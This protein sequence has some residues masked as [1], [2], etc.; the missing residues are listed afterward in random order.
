LK[1]PTIKTIN[2]GTLGGKQIR[3]YN[4][5]NKTATVTENNETRPM[6]FREQTRVKAM[7]TKM[8]KGLDHALMDLFRDSQNAPPLQKLENN[9]ALLKQVLAGRIGT[10][11]AK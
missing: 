3:V 6:T 1:S 10:T 9:L 2:H 4:V 7:V 11:N 8:A 5:K